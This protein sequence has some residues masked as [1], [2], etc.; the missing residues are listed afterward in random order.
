[1]ESLRHLSRPTIEALA[2][3]LESGRLASDR[4]ADLAELVPAAW[5]PQVAEEL[6]AAAGGGSKPVA[7]ALRALAAE[8]A[9][10]EAAADGCELVWSG[11]GGSEARNT[12]IVVQQLF[13]TARRKLLLASYALEQIQPT[14]FSALAARMAA[15]PALVVQFFVNV[16]RRFGDARDE[17]ELVR[18]YAD[19]FRSRAWPGKRLPAIFYDPRAMT[20]GEKRA[21]L[22]AKC[23]V[24]DDE[25]A[26]VTSANFT[27]AAHERNFEAGILLR[28]SRVARMLAGQF[29]QLRAEGRVLELKS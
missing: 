22:H 16:E 24:A 7:A 14:L 10:A 19:S 11:G 2:V 27:E 25:I 26:F 29:E 3:A 20:L 5:L 9:A 1:M 23:I 15:E 17:K 21:C 28:N 12:A 6:R 8:R 13:R 4:E 18:E